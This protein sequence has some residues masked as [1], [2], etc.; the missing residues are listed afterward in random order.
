M[1]GMIKMKTR[2]TTL[3]SLVWHRGLLFWH[4]PVSSWT[5]QSTSWCYE[6]LREILE[7]F[8]QFGYEVF[9]IGIFVNTNDNN[10]IE[11]VNCRQVMLNEPNHESH[12]N[13]WD[14]TISFAT[15]EWSTL[16]TTK[17]NIDS[18]NKY[19]LTFPW[20]LSS[21]LSNG[22]QP[23]FIYKSSFNSPRNL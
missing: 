9:I 8:P 11:C 20:I 16:M 15:G 14:Q 7:A 1:V 22:R 19:I 12:C 17:L 13:A 6:V 23:N 4:P 2:L 3:P 18:W 21:F 10:I 5:T